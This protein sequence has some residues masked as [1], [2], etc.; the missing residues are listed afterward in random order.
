M[1][2]NIKIKR[3]PLIFIVIFLLLIII[4][5]GGYFGY[6]I[7]YNKKAAAPKTEITYSLDD[8][9]VNTADTGE[10]RYIKTKIYIGYT[11]SKL[12]EELDTKKPILRDTVN[13]ILYSKKASQMNQ[14]G[15][16]IMK[17]EIKDKLNKILI[18]GK[19]DNIYYY[20]VLL[21]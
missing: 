10:R 12:T 7:L 19:I 6:S 4:A 1:S 14:A 3:S 20:D 18:T 21:Q 2:E 17:T 13:S 5:G 11:E 15:L 8:F 16:E 9:L